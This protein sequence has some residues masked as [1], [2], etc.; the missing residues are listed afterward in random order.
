MQY[1]HKVGDHVMYM[2]NGVGKIVDIR[3]EQFIA[4]MPRTYFVLSPL[5]DPRSEIYVPVDSDNLTA[6]I[7]ELLT[8]KEIKKAIK[9][10]EKSTC[11][12][13]PDVKERSA[14]F[15]KIISTG[16]R[17]AILAVINTLNEY[18]RE[19]ESQKKKFYASDER[20][21][22]AANKFITEEFSFVLGIPH[23]SVMQ[24]I[25]KNLENDAS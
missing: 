18:R 6:N 14:E 17:A 7:F 25:T 24:Y 15:S 23:E 10:S 2:N 4:G 16:N 22:N 1:A 13:I 3:E 12:W 5:G 19:L 9:D 11:E 20:L 21:F 8:E